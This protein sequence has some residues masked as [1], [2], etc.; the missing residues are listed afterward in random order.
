MSASAFKVIELHIL[1]PN[2]RGPPHV[3]VSP[4]ISVSSNSFRK[5]NDAFHIPLTMTLQLS[6]NVSFFFG[7]GGFE[8]KPHSWF[9]TE[10]MYIPHFSNTKC[11]YLKFSEI[12]LLMLLSNV[13]ITNFCSQSNF[14]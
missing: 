2:F 1:E 9:S 13:S 8:G 10:Y 11:S 6:I 14:I 7:F 4:V 5:I 12:T 3:F